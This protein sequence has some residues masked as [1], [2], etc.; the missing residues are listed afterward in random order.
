MATFSDESTLLPTS[1]EIRSL[2]ARITFNH[3]IKLLTASS[4]KIH[5][6]FWIKISVSQIKILV[7]V[8]TYS[9]VYLNDTFNLH[10]G[11]CKYVLLI[12]LHSSCAGI[13]KF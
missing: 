2:Y 7:T 6:N 8:S 1:F 11:I 13:L 9:Q 10:S 5:P 4:K 3:R 12:S